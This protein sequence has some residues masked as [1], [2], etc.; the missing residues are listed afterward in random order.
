VSEGVFSCPA[1]ARIYDECK[2]SSVAVLAAEL[3]A[4][5]DEL[6]RR[7]AWSNARLEEVQHCCD[8]AVKNRSIIERAVAE[9]E[10][11]DAPGYSPA[12]LRAIAILNGAP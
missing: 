1:C 7:T 6:A 8:K 2:G 10:G 11:E 9:L 4:T 3:K 12:V 5:Q